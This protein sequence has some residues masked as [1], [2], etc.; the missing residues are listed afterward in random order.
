MTLH[1]EYI[2]GL[3]KVNGRPTA[4]SRVFEISSSTDLVDHKT[5]C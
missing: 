5:V 2:I 1:T 3:S 4:A